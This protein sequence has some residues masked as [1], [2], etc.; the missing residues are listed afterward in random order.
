MSSDLDQRNQFG[1]G[2]P[3]IRHDQPD[4]QPLPHLPPHDPGGRPRVVAEQ[5]PSPHPQLS[6][7]WPA[8]ARHRVGLA[9]RRDE[10]ENWCPAQVPARGRSAYIE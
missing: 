10:P 3:A 4:P 7:D 5:G 6:Q 2:G 9:Q 8:R 1:R